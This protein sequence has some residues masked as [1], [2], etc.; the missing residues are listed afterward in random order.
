M[1][2]QEQSGFLE[3]IMQQRSLNVSPGVWAK[4]GPCYHCTAS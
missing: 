3:E 2:Q 1:A 4:I